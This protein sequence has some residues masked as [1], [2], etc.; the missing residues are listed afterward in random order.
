MLAKP[1]QME[2]CFWFS[3]LDRLVLR[4]SIRVG[5][6][7][8]SL[9]LGNIDPHSIQKPEYHEKS[10]LHRKTLLSPQDRPCR[11]RKSRA[12]SWNRVQEVYAVT[13]G[14]Q[15]VFYKYETHQAT[16]KRRGL[17]LLTHRSGW[18]HWSLKYE[19]YR[20]SL[21]TDSAEVCCLFAASDQSR[22]EH[23]K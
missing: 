6:V 12:P 11:Q 10:G 8:R 17:C 20:R 21:S 3:S 14:Y 18:R 15:N 22:K 16:G 2:M 4:R 13:K 5:D 23:L 1:L 7:Y 9:F 19:F